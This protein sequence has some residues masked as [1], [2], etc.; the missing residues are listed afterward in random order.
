MQKALSLLLGETTAITGA[1]RTDAGVHAKQLF[2]HFDTEKLVQEDLH[3]RLNA[4]LPK[5]I[6]IKRIVKVKQEAHA[7]FDALYRSYEY[8]INLSHDPFLYDISWQVH[9]RRFDVDAMNKAA[10]I[11]LKHTNF[12]AFSKSKTDVKTYNCKITKAQWVQTGEQLVFYI[13]ADRFLR[14]MVRAIVGTLLDVG[15]GKLNTTDFEQIILSQNRSQ[16]GFSVPASGLF[17]TEV[18]YPERIF[19]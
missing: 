1:G 10:T 18:G 8:H 17:L 16:A 2:A 14:N 4:L 12:K 7:R 11:L 15:K 5:T 3:Y 19:L 6:V 9:N 13:T